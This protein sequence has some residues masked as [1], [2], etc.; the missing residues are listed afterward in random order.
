M[1]APWATPRPRRARCSATSPCSRPTTALWPAPAATRPRSP[2]PTC[3]PTTTWSS[4]ACCCK[5]MAWSWR[6]APA[7]SPFPVHFSFAE[8]DHVEG[9]LSAERRLLMRDVFDLP[10][11][12]AMDDGIANGT[13][14]PGPASRSRCRCS[15]RR[16]WTIRCTA[17][18]TTPAPRPSTSRT[19]CCSPTTSSTSTSSC[20]W[21]T[22]RWPSP[23][24][25]TS[26]SSSPA[27]WSRAAWA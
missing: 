19:S 25:N 6:W 16:G 4:S 1:W 26:P 21:A 22:K 24:A 9:T 13:W 17:C 7:R 20:A 14:E 8:H 2:A 15:P 11:L 27:T 12:A 3:T 18:A 10:D 23:T 5:T